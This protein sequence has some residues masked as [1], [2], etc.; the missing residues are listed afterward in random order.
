M[1][2]GSGTDYAVG[3]GQTY[4]KVG[5]VP[6][7]RLGAGDTVRIHHRA[8]P[9]REKIMVGGIGRPTD[10]I[11]VCGVKGPKGERPVLDGQRAST[12]PTMDYPFDGHQ[13]RGLVVIGKRYAA[14]WSETP[15]HVVL[16]GL[17]LRN[18][19]PPHSFFDRTGKETPWPGLAAGVFVQRAK[20]VTIRDCEIHG[21]GN[22][23]FIGSSG[24]DELTSDVLVEGNHIHGNASVTDWYSHNMYNEASGVVIQHNHFGPPRSGPRGVLGANIKERSA[25]VVI[26][27]NWIEDGAHVIDLVD[28]QEARDPNLKDPAFRETWLYGN[29]IIR[30]K[31]ASGSMIHYGGDSGL[32]DTY[33]KGTLHALH[34]T[35]VVLNATHADY[36]GT[37]LFE[38][39]TNDEKLDLRNNVIFT[40]DPPRDTR[41][42]VILGARDQVVMGV[43]ELRGNWISTGVAEQDG[44]P[45]G[46]TKRQGTVRGLAESLRGTDPGFVDWKA[47][48][49]WPAPTSALIGR[50]VAR[51]GEPHPITRQ[52]LLHGRD[53]PRPPETPPTIGAFAPRR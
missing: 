46:S 29:V 30:G 20:H 39:S 45:G 50:G 34:N 13:P 41:P 31:Q 52:Y 49:L 27:Y 32:T 43:A 10:P 26:R 18:A 11:R 35:V 8:E 4:E 3:P 7:E 6:W 14:P 28:A 19:S 47:R 16:E 17:E 37:A 44:I 23:L 21:N 1:H 22:G 12:R 36:E 33:R 53:E 40:E 25:G 2:R 9:Y 15:E 51:A 24:G 38:I 48:S 5:D 42:V